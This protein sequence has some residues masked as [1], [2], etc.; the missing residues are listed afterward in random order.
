MF[1]F[2]Q[3]LIDNE[4]WMKFL[5]FLIAVL[6]GVLQ[7][8]INSYMTRVQG[9]VA[10]AV[11]PMQDKIKLL[12]TGKVNLY[13]W[14]FKLPGNTFLFKRARLISAGTAD[15]SYYW[16]DPPQNLQIGQEFEGM[17][18]LEDEFGRKWVSE[19]GGELRKIKV[20]AEEKMAITIW[21]YK[22]YQKRWS[23]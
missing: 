8:K 7:L 17:L 11:I 3:F 16:I 9:Y 21:T 23:F 13:L 20:D 10:V 12:N 5:T 4:I 6:F 19:F 22:T 14:G 2:K 15:S 1:D 18:Y